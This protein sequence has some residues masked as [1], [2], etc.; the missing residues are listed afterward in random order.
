MSPSRGG[1]G[2]GFG[3][4]EG[5]DQHGNDTGLKLRCMACHSMHLLVRPLPLMPRCWISGAAVQGELRFDYVP[6]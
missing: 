6:F 4:G 3:G 1:E 2:G 5:G